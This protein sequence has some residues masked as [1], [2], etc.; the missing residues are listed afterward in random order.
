MKEKIKQI[1]KIVFMV[2]VVATVSMYWYDQYGYYFP[3]AENTQSYCSSNNNVAVIK[4]RGNIVTYDVPQTNADGTQTAIPDTTSAENVLSY[5]DEI[6]NNDN[7]KGV[8]VEIDSGGGSPT[9][10]EEIMRALKNIGKPTV[11]AIREQGNSAAYLIAT[12]TDKIYANKMSDVGSIGVTMSYLDYSQ[13]NIKDGITY[14]Q[15]STG[16]FKDSGDP[17]KVLTKEEKEKFLQE[18]QKLHQLFVEDVAANRN[19]NIDVV[20]KLAD[21]ST[22]VAQEAKDKGL[23]DEV[24]SMDDVKAWL[25]S[26][27]G[28]EP[29]LCIY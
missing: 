12:G 5:I 18:L 26:Q 24:G 10:G 1:S 19:L 23:I 15:I 11:A 29:D 9:A 2:V 22:M 28:I 3:S 14:Q 4:I 17:D 6:K 25:G 21:G 16:K 8:I 27:L 7:I 20:N 13:Q